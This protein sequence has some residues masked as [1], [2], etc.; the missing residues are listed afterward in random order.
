MFDEKTQQELKQYV[1]MLLDPQNDKP[2]YVGKGKNNRVFK[3]MNRAIT[4]SDISTLKYE[5]IREIVEDKEQTLKHVIVRH[6]LTDSE[7]FQIEASLIDTLN[8]CGLG[9]SN[10]QGGRNS[11]DKGLMTSEEII[12]LYNAQPLNKIGNDCILININKSY[13]RGN[14]TNSIYQATKETWFIDKN[15]VKHLKYV[16]SEYRGLIV[17]V[18][19]VDNNGWYQK[20]R[21]KYKTIYDENKK[22][23]LDE[24]GKRKK[25]VVQENG[26]GF[27]GKP[28]PDSIRA[29]YI[30]K[31]VKDK[32]IQGQANVIRYK[33]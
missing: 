10:Q 2:F 30:N 22:P 12:R 20:P 23:I 31:S 3:H 4:D 1:Y 19:E 14:G 32:K 33:L 13:K 5:K 15:K 11:I 16:L 17:E 24:K 29:L 18:F 25:E 27:S 6:G 9:L 26:F 28:A 21:T 8:Y 7:A